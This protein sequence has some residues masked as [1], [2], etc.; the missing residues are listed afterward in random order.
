[1]EEDEA[2]LSGKGVRVETVRVDLQGMDGSQLCWTYGLNKVDG[3][4]EVPFAV[5]LY[6][7]ELRYLSAGAQGVIA[8]AVNTRSGEAVAIKMLTCD[9]QPRHVLREIRTLSLG[10]HHCNLT[11]ATEMYYHIR[12]RSKLSVYIVMPLM[13]GSLDQ[14]LDH[15]KRWR[16]S[17]SEPAT[18][19]PQDTVAMV[20]YQ[21]LRG[22]YFLHSGGVHHR[23]LAPK[24]VLF[25]PV[26]N[27]TPV[28]HAE[29]PA[30]VRIPHL[31][32]RAIDLIADVSVS[33]EE[34]HSAL[35]NAALCEP[36]LI[37][38][39]LMAKGWDQEKGFPG[40]YKRGEFAKEIA[41]LFLRSESAGCVDLAP[42]DNY[43]GPPLR[44]RT[45]ITDFGLSRT[46]VGDASE[47]LTDYV[48]TRHYRAPE[49]I[50]GQGLHTYDAVKVDVWSLGC[51]IGEMLSP[52]LDTLL[53][54]KTVMQQMEYIFLL[55]GVP[56]PGEVESFT[57]RTTLN[58]V[59]MMKEKERQRGQPFGTNFAKFFAGASPECVEALQ[60]M[61]VLSP[62]KR[63]TLEHLLDLPF[64]R[65][66]AAL[67]GYPGD[68]ISATQLGSE[69]EAVMQ[70]APN[71]TESARRQ[72]HS[73]TRQLIMSEVCTILFR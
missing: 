64:F 22:L 27:G 16:A 44:I 26:P 63:A 55:L 59:R 56:D 72:R 17:T 7:K 37:G 57:T 14:W 43:N 39:L 49:L 34:V 4:V 47:Q 41:R 21:S 40:G 15:Y 71:E 8:K 33:E 67:C 10:Q 28:I 19:V 29:Q 32:Q 61:L 9:A 62:T 24:N 31:V 73:D 45:S 69:M 68:L 54:G 58:F 1:M 36:V 65:R 30:K 42:V 66:G 48:V 20:A 46:V 38:N 23:D 12:E 52:R 5:P 11:C 51:V 13:A 60:A 35:Y 6:Y 25:Q 18:P 53:P 2:L 70:A 50:L 3:A